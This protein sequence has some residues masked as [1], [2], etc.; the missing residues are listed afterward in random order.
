MRKALLLFALGTALVG[1]QG[2]PGAAA[3]KHDLAENGGRW[4]STRRLVKTEWTFHSDGSYDAL[5]QEGEVAAQIRGK[6]RWDNGFL[7]V[8]PDRDSI[9]ARSRDAEEAGR[10]QDR[11][12][13]GYVLAITWN[14]NDKFTAKPTDGEEA[15]NFVRSQG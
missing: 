5:H 15:L 12:S 1:C 8:D 14:G 13:K 10:V 2:G 6:Y 11:L 3:V 7:V 4:L 9:E